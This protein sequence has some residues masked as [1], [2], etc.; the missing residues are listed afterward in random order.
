MQVTGVN[1]DR[2]PTVPS[3]G[4]SLVPRELS[5]W[6]D[7]QAHG[8]FQTDSLGRERE[9]DQGQL[10]QRQAR[11]Q[12]PHTPAAPRAKRL[13]MAKQ[14]APTAPCRAGVPSGG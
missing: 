14:L 8:S 9:G 7:S 4:L 2:V 5:L 11:L 13:H 3:G 6:G 10:G 1:S 12:P